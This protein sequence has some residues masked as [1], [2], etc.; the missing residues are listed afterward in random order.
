MLY[1]KC[2]DINIFTLRTDKSWFCPAKEHGGHASSSSQSEF[3]SKYFFKYIY[4]LL[5]PA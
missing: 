3:I 4:L 2:V 5:L 1:H